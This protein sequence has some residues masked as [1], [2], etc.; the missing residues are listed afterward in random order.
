MKTLLKDTSQESGL[1]VEAGHGRVIPNDVIGK[2]NLG[3]EVELSGHDFFR[4]IGRKATTI[5]EPCALRRWGTGN[6]DYGGKMRLG[7]GFVKERD[8]RAKPA[9]TFRSLPSLGDP[10]GANSRMKDLL[11]FAPLEGIGKDHF[12]KAGAIRLPC[13]IKAIISKNNS[14]GFLHASILSEQI[15]RTSISVERYGRQESP[16]TGGETGFPRRDTTS[17]ANGWH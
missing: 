7:I 17:D 14:D 3:C 1:P 13:G 12:A 10:G 2:S 15:V 16:Q 5:E 11:E 8:I 4:G 6:H 9:V